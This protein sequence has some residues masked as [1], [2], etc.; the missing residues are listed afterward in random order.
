MAYVDCRMEALALQILVVDMDGRVSIVM[1]SVSDQVIVEI[2]DSLMLGSN[3]L[4]T[5]K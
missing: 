2:A 1:V 4:P 5:R 3:H